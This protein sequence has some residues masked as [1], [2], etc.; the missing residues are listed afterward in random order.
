MSEGSSQEGC[1]G[2]RE[3]EGAI[4]RCQASRAARR[5]NNQLSSHTLRLP[6]P[7]SGVPPLSPPPPLTP[8]NPLPPLH[9]FMSLF[10]NP[11]PLFS[12]PPHS[13][14]QFVN[15]I[16]TPRQADCPVV[17]MRP[18]PSTGHHRGL[19]VAVPVYRVPLYVNVRTTDRRGGPVV[20]ASASRAGDTGSILAFPVGIF[21]GR[22]ISMT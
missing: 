15:R 9:P 22:V 7:S 12:P 2:E 21:P 10:W 6:F 1:L 20:K 17:A 4:D 11:T 3:R 5:G 16:L 19:Q 13:L 8:L 18:G 14:T